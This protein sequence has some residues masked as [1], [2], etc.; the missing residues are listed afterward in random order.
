[1]TDNREFNL[2]ERRW[3]SERTSERREELLREIAE[4]ELQYALKYGIYRDL[5]TG[6]RT[7]VGLSREKTRNRMRT[8]RLQ[9]RCIGLPVRGRAS[10]SVKKKK[11][12]RTRD[13]ESS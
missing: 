8:R 10:K 1:M 5:V 3:L 4:A 12:Q 9:H 11:N 6:D 7:E 13:V 2:L